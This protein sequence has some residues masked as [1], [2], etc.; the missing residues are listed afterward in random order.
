MWLRIF[1]KI[2]IRELVR[3][4]GPRAPNPDLD[5]EINIDAIGPLLKKVGA[6][7]ITGME[8]LI[9]ELDEARSYLKAEGERLQHEAAHYAN[10]TQTANAS[11]KIISESLRDWRP[12]GKL[13]SS[14]AA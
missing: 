6:A 10:L 8:K 11:V 13:R 4:E 2:K 12:A 5:A 14:K 3:G 7:S 9:H 1:A